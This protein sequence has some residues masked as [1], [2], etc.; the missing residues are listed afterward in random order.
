M[1]TDKDNPGVE[2]TKPTSTRRFMLITFLKAFFIGIGI[3]SSFYHKQFLE[4]TETSISSETFT[5][6]VRSLVVVFVSLGLYIYFFV[7]K[8][9]DETYTSYKSGVDYGLSNVE[10]ISSRKDAKL[11][12][13]YMFGGVA[14][15]VALHLVLQ[16]LWPC[17]FGPI[18][19]I[20]CI[21]S[22]NDYIDSLV[23]GYIKK[24]PR[25]TSGRLVIPR[26]TSGRLM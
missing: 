25:S 15:L 12:L 24:M 17:F 3:I 7:R 18:V 22:N 20:I 4:M 21:L 2:A 5:L 13:L 16:E 26:S 8:H 1:C 9:I 10:K 14:F 19:V 11:T 23:R 6:I